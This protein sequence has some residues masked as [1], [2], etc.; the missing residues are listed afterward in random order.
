MKNFANEARRSPSPVEQLD[1]GA[2]L[3]LKRYEKPPPSFYENFLVEFQRRQ[4]VA[5]AVPKLHERIY[6]WFSQHVVG[7]LPDFRVP[8]SAYVAVGILAVGISSWILTTDKLG[9][10]QGEAVAMEEKTENAGDLL[11]MQINQPLP[12]VF[13]YPVNIP[14]Q[15]R[16]ST[17]PP[18]YSLESIPRV[19]SQP[20][21]F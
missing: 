14:S 9:T 21:S 7:I 5:A 20:F 15:I 19:E 13:L 17:L 11:K 4:R 6:D 18:N 1:V 3:R 12:E 10:T 16:V 8:V 2:L